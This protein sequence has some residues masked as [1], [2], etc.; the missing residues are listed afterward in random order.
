MLTR[1]KIKK[2]QK[3]RLIGTALSPVEFTRLEEISQATGLNRSQIIREGLRL[4]DKEYKTLAS[5][6]AAIRAV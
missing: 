6:S 2:N 3:S 1:E 5:E 4:I